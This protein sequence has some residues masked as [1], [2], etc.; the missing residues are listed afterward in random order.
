MLMQGLHELPQGAVPEGYMDVAAEIT[1]TCRSMYNTQSG[2]APEI[3]DFSSGTKIIKPKDAFSL[4]RPEAVEAM[5]YMWYYTGDHKYREWA[6]SV[7][8][9]LNRSARCQHG[10]SAVDSVDDSA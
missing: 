5:Y 4:L 8:E 2:L 9:G 1:V 10:F 7:L 3:V 6:N